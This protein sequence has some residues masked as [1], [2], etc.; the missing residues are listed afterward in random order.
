MAGWA[1][2]AE[3]LDHENIVEPSDKERSR[4]GHREASVQ[5]GRKP[6]GEKEVDGEART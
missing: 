6:S 2:D 3:R 5:R 1:K 4:K